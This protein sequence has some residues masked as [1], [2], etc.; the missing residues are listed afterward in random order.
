MESYLEV[1]IRIKVHENVHGTKFR[2]SLTSLYACTAAELS[3]QI[4]GQT[5][6]IGNFLYGFWILSGIFFELVTEDVS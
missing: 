1:E 2:G 3:W 4:L 5:C 6:H